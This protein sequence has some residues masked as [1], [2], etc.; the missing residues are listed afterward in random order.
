MGSSVEITKCVCIGK[1]PNNPNKHC[2]L[3][4]GVN[5]EF[6]KK[7]ILRNS[8]KLRGEDKPAHIKKILLL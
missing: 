4:I 3:K 5:M 1:K 8:V 2:L 7:Q 6:V